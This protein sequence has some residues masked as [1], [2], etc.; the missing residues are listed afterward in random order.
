[1]SKPNNEC[2]G[3]NQRETKGVTLMHFHVLKQYP[4]EMSFLTIDISPLGEYTNITVI[5]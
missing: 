5:T 4:C 2:R 3:S 1:M